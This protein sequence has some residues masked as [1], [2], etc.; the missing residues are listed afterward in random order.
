MGIIPI[1]YILKDASEAEL[2]HHPQALSV[3]K[4]IV[5]NDWAQQRRF[6]VLRPF[7][8]SGNTGI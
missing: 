3:D 1:T 8:Y 7:F 6:L 4:G 5:C 2:I